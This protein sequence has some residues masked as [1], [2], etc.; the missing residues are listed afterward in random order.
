VR[1]GYHSIKRE[2][3]T[4][5]KRGEVEAHSRGR[6]T[7]RAYCPLSYIKV[8]M[9]LFSTH[10]EA[11]SLS[12]PCCSTNKA[13]AQRCTAIDSL[14]LTLRSEGGGDVTESYM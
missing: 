6:R 13:N 5:M 11:L 10:L 7:P 8:A 12:L 3:T 2:V 1:G 9:L 4:T 14:P